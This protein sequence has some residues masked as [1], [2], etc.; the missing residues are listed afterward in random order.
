MQTALVIFVGGGTGSVLRWLVGNS[1]ARAAG[2]GFPWGTLA[3]NLIGCGVLGL[4]TGWLAMR[5]QLNETWRLALVTGVLGGFTTFSAFSLDALTL[6]QRG[7]S[8]LAAG[9]ILASV[10][11]GL[12]ALVGGMAVFKLI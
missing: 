9:Y 5:G 11:L 4:L 2:L 10:A 1:V 12:L 8:A 6:W 3:V 7:E